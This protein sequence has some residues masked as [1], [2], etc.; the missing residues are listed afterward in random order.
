M[1]SKKPEK[2]KNN[3]MRALTLS[4]VAASA[5]VFSVIVVL[6]N[7]VPYSGEAPNASTSQSPVEGAS[8][9]A[10]DLGYH[11][12]ESTDAPE[13][14]EAPIESSEAES[15]AEKAPE[16]TAPPVLSLSF[17]SNGDGTCSVSGLGS[18]PSG[19]VSIPTLSPTGDV[20]TG[21]GKYAFYNETGIIRITIPSTVRSIG[22][23]AFF[24]CTALLE[25]T[26]SASNTAFTVSDGLLYT[27][28]GSRL[29]L[30][31][32]MRGKSSCILSRDVTVIDR[33]AFS[34]VTSLKTV[35]YQGSA[36]E[37]TAIEIGAHNELLDGIRLVCNY[38][39]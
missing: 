8:R 34:G 20:V 10:A 26:V 24:G 39:G 36:A 25:V 14:T 2:K 5:L 30:C 17:S 15:T 21:I 7:T 12:P 27:R 3:A 31:P 33:G 11:T 9:P 19:D 37:W 18:Y 29:I 4:L 6:F 23:Y 38:T 28:D 22:E 16:T 1:E 13:S 32:A 35:Y